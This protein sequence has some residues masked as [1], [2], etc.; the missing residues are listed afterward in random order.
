MTTLERELA[1]A[2]WL[3]LL[4]RDIWCKN[5]FAP[6]QVWFCYFSYW[7]AWDITEKMPSDVTYPRKNTKDSKA[8]KMPQNSF[9]LA[10]P[11]TTVCISVKLLCDYLPGT[12]LHIA[13]KELAYPAK[14]AQRSDFLKQQVPSW[15]YQANDD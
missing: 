6:C 7:D 14:P 15:I 9:P 11:F 2:M 13:M 8:S 10:Q 12:H 1:E 5:S 4:K 3:Q